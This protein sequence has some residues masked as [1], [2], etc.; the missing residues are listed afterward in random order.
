MMQRHDTL[1][2]FLGGYDLEMVTIRQLLLE[3]AP[4]QFYDKQLSWGAK[5][6]AYSQEVTQTLSCGLTPV[7]VELMQDLDLQPT[8]FLVV[9][10][11][12]ERAGEQKP[13]SLHQVFELLGLPPERWTRWYDLVAAN[14]RGYIPALV[15][16]GATPEEVVTVRAADRAAQGIT[17][18]EEA[19]GERAVAHAETCANGMIT[20]VRLPHSRTATV[21]DR[22]HPALGG[23]GYHNLLVYCPDQVNFFGTGQLVHT[24]AEHFPGG[25]YG[26]ALPAKGFWGHETPL[27]DILPVILNHLASTHALSASTLGPD[28]L[29][30]V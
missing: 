7:F 30:D 26:G 3:V 10:H 29:D 11:H 20:A 13:T 27:P 15:E 14:D 25:W 1:V 16:M 19:A 22:L 21:T 5:A 2:F 18:A 28:C 6:S 23:K 12:G 8:Q 9:D 17:P 4:K 24:L